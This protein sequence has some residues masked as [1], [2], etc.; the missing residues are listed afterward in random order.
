MNKRYITIQQARKLI[1]TETYKPITKVQKVIGYSILG[2]GLI[3][4]PLPTGSIVLIMIGASLLG[5]NY[6]DILSKSQFLIR[7]RFI[8][9]KTSKLIRYFK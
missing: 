4:I 9:F 6:K 3:T 8:D 7:E 1:M 5:L 2:L